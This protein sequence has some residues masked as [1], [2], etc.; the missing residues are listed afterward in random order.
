MKIL[1]LAVLLNAQFSFAKSNDE[2]ILG[3]TKLVCISWMDLKVEIK[4]QSI[5]EYAMGEINFVQ[6]DWSYHADVIEGKLNA[7]NLKYAPL[8]LETQSFAD[9]FPLNRLSASLSVHGK[10]ASLDCEIRPVLT[11]TK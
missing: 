6:G 5:S 4:E 8:D 3:P 1:I 10:K 9:S 11:G 2:I 7:L